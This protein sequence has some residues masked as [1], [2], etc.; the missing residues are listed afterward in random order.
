MA[1]Q[2]DLKEGEEP[3]KITR[4][5]CTGC[6]VCE[7]IC[8]LVHTGTVNPVLARL[9]ILSTS[10]YKNYP[11]IC[12]HCEPPKC[13]EVCP[14]PGALYIDS[15][16]RVLFLND[17]KCTHC[18]ACVEACPFDAIFVGPNGEPLKCDLCG[19]DPQCVKY[20]Y[21]RPAN[22]FPHLPS[23]DQA[24][25]QHDRNKNRGVGINGKHSDERTKISGFGKVLRIDLTTGKISTEE[26][27]IEVRYKYMGGLA[28]NDWLFWNHFLEVSPTIDPLSPENVMILGVG[29]LSGTAYPVAGKMRWTFK[30]PITGI[31]GD[32]SS[33]GRFVS[34]L[35]WA[36]YDHVII[37]G[38]ASSPVYLWIDD[39][40]VEIRDAKHIWGKDPS[41]AERLI[42][43]ELGDD[44]IQ[45]AI[46]GQAGENGVLFGSVRVGHRI[47]GRCGSGTVLGSK[48]LKGIAV[49]GT[50][51][52]EIHDP[53]ALF[54]A[55]DEQLKVLNEASSTK[56]FQKLGSTRAWEPYQGLGVL[57]YRNGQR[58]MVP[59]KEFEE[60]CPEFYL[61][62]LGRNPIGCHGCAVSCTSVYEVKGDETPCAH[63]YKGEIAT[64]GELGAMMSLGAM[65]GISDWAVFNHLWER[66]NFYAMD[67]FEISCTCGLLME[68]WQ[69]GFINQKDIEE[70]MGEPISLNWGNYEVVEKII[71]S[72]G[73]QTNKLGKMV[74]KG[75]YKLA[76]EI[77]KIKGVSVLRYA[78][79]G[80]GGSA[81][82]EDIRNTP[83]WAVNF[84]VAT[85]GAD[86]LKGMG[87]LDKTAGPELAIKYFGTPDA[88][89]LNTL[90][91]G[92]SSAIRE[93]L[94]GLNNSL[95]ICLFL[96]K[97]E[98]QYPPERLATAVKA[99]TGIDFTA[100]DLVLVGERSVNLEKAFNSR[101]GLRRE[102]DILCERFM[103]EPQPDGMG[104]KAEDYL[105]ELKSEQYEWH[106]WDKETSLQTRKKL[107]ELGLEEVADVL[108]KEDALVEN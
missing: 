11:I 62:K 10:D 38:K 34:S 97:E 91:K 39:D 84:A 65:L 50:K 23:V 47:A 88:F 82:T 90:F 37:T 67:V 57:F 6:G 19:G 31:F 99:V 105:E 28:V 17:E 49:R 35:K 45:T 78:L 2:I 25:L 86:H 73:L 75:V 46:I 103:K 92:A 32:S 96:A 68:L 43:K 44:T 61:Q 81:H 8:S 55:F 20:C 83:G 71:K 54:K 14:V 80:K 51:G 63:L 16:T 15:K 60:M 94:N 5:L 108:A 95:G 9:R 41:E 27:P 36:G 22:N 56:I 106:G 76:K 7:M 33:G 21:P 70:W 53:Q 89:G 66:C 58:N 69:K 52:T 24:C 93:N 3:I 64:R 4:D 59:E 1:I 29:V 72:V 85:R 104:W 74:G 87:T 30:S 100:R 107:E 40:K 12:R 48:N 13:L 79:Y 98:L 101:L 42:R 77:D 18:H 26:I 102:D